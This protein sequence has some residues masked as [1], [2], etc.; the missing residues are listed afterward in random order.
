MRDGKGKLTFANHD[1]YEGYWKE[2][3]FFGQGELNLKSR[4]EVL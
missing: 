1:T 3:N 2:N 4:N